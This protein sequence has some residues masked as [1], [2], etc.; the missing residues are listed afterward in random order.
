MQDEPNRKSERQQASMTVDGAVD[1]AR[2]VGNS[3]RQAFLAH[4]DEQQRQYPMSLSG[5]RRSG[6]EARKR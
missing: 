2:A 5:P 1:S 3:I 6:G 4:M